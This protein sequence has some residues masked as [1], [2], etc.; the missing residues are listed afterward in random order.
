M[1]KHVDVDEVAAEEVDTEKKGKSGPTAG[2][3]EHS[4]Q[5]ARTD[6]EDW[7]RRRPQRSS[8]RKGRSQDK[9]RDVTR[10][11]YKT[12]DG[13][14]SSAN[15]W[16]ISRVRTT[17]TRERLVGKT[18]MTI[19]RVRLETAGQTTILYKLTLGEVDT[20]I[21]GDR[22][23]HVRTPRALR[24]ASVT[25]ARRFQ[26]GDVEY[27]NIEQHAKLAQGRVTVSRMCRHDE[28]CCDTKLDHE[29]HGRM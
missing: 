14:S 26:R 19:L 20:T 8:F 11:V 3:K 9:A 16:L 10:I 4:Q 2:K 17:R 25:L 22:F 6:K 27:K 12:T 5:Q 23:H 24:T 1:D 21:P 13:E 29:V 7:L 28:L 18:E 15:S